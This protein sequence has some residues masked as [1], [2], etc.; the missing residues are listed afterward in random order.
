MTDMLPNTVQGF[1]VRGPAPRVRERVPSQ[2]AQKRTNEERFHHAP[3]VG[4]GGDSNQHVPGRHLSSTVM[5]SHHIS[6]QTWV[7]LTM[8]SC[9]ALSLSLSAPITKG[10]PPPA[11]RPHGRLNNNRLSTTTFCTAFNYE[12]YVLLEPRGEEETTRWRLS[13]RR[14]NR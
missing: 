5:I 2:R 8:S 12:S 10:A 7:P 3:H 11:R 4:R 13:S 14:C 6:G 9:Y 1:I